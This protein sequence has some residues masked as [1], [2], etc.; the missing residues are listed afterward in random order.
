M[1]KRTM[2]IVSTV[3]ALL[4]GPITNAAQAASGNKL[5]TSHRSL[6]ATLVVNAVSTDG[7]KVFAAGY[8]NG[9]YVTTADDASTGATLWTKTYPGGNATAI[10]PSPD[11][12]R[13]FVTGDVFANND[14][15]WA[16]IAYDAETG[17]Q[18][19]AKSYDGPVDVDDFFDSATGVTVSPD[20]ATV[21]VT[22]HTSSLGGDGNALETVAYDADTGDVR[23]ATRENGFWGCQSTGH[24]ITVSPDGA[25][26]LV[27]GEASGSGFGFG[28]LAFEASTGQRL[29][30]HR[31]YGPAGNAQAYA[32]VVA[33]DGSRVLQTGQ[34]F[35]DADGYNYATLAYDVS[36]GSLDWSKKYAGL[37]SVAGDDSAAGIAVGPTS[38]RVFVT[39][40]SPNET[41]LDYATIAYD[42]STGDKLWGRRYD[43]PGTSY[44]A[45]IVIGADGVDVF[46][47]GTSIG[48]TDPSSGDSDFFTIAYDAA[49][50]STAWSQRFREG[51]DF[52][53][54]ATAIATGGGRVFVTGTDDWGRTVAYAP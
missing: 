21:F 38:D 1:S 31:W 45:G 30:A 46:V 3:T 7:S 13:V 53:Q 12:T 28:T 22:G 9:E 18:L 14:Y 26:V 34:V 8:G 25:D 42:A 15:D 43:G 4:V 29:W 50:G 10:A 23:W 40:T 24:A 51:D 5:W 16:T 33:P 35:T 6:G 2:W 47:T 11:G 52:P 39:G 20:S 48:S 32:I 37:S 44:A 49:V 27:C 36:T 41:Q 19:W 17:E 54:Q